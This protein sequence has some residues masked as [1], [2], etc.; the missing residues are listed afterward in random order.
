M[1]IAVVDLFGLDGDRLPPC[2]PLKIGRPRILSV[3]ARN[4]LV[5]AS[6][7][8]STEN[9]ATAC[10]NLKISSCAGNC[11]PPGKISVAD[12]YRMN[13][14]S[15]IV[16]RDAALMHLFL[17]DDRQNCVQQHP[18]VIGEDVVGAFTKNAA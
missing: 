16:K 12:G 4:A 10:A 17:G 2:W 6:C 8:F 13:R 14:R 1:H 7:T 15:L 9:P 18:A 5:A 11:W 3:H